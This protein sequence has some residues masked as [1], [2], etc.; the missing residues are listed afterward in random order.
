ME[1]IG[2]TYLKEGDTAPDFTFEDN[3]GKSVKL[4]DYRGRKDMIVYFYPKDFTPGCSTE[5]TEFTEDYE[6]FRRKDVEILGISSDD[7]DSHIR[8]RQKFHIPY[9]LVSDSENLVSKLYGVYGTK[10]FMGKEYLGI[11]RST[12]LIDKKGKITKIFYKV[13]PSGHS[14]EVREL[15]AVHTASND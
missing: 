8:F 15:F 9:M 13:K 2:P 1:G 3:N 6:E 5:A 14:K 7:M 11:T 10:K 4:S 12:F